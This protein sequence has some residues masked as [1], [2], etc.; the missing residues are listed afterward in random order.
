MREG[1]NRNAFREPIDQGDLL[2]Q[3][4]L[5]GMSRFPELKERMGY[6]VR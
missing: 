6:L 4:K 1:R 2:G 3:E 5:Y